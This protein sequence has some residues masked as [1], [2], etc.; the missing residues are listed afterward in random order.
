MSKADEARQ[1][2][3]GAMLATPVGERI[4]TTQVLAEAAGVGYGTIAAAIRGLVGDG[5]VEVSTHGHRGTRLRRRGTVE[6]WEAAG[7]A[8]LVGVLPL[9]QSTEF[10]GLSTAFSTI[11][12]EQKVPLQLLFRQGSEDRLTA[13]R[14][15]R[16]DWIATSQDAADATSDDCASTG[17]GDHSYYAENAAVVLTA[18]GATPRPTGRVPVDSSS[19]DHLLLTRAEFPDASLVEAAYLT[20]PDLIVS[21]RVDAAVWH[22]TSV[23]SLFTAGG[24]ALHPLS[25]PSP[26][27]RPELS[28]AAIVWRRSDLAVSALLAELFPPDVVAARQREVLRGERTPSF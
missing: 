26:A 9:P 2:V 7:R 16:V 28:R 15:G 8:P 4:P 12:E 11:A 20:I 23:S 13:L 5:L 3:A 10:L 19:H 21:G 17:L 14:S 22:R 1:V 27:Q 18:L 6:L 24:L 25:R